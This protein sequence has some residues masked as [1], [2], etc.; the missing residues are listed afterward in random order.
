MFIVCGPSVGSAEKVLFEDKGGEGYIAPGLEAGQGIAAPLTHGS[1]IT[2]NAPGR[3]REDDINLVASAISASAGHHGHSSPRGDGSDNL[4]P[5]PYWDGGEISDTLDSS[6]LAKQQAMPEKRRF[7]AV[8]TAASLIG[9]GQYAEGVGPLRETGGDCGGG[10]ET[11]ISVNPEVCNALGTFSGGPDDNDA[12]GAHIVIQDVRGGTRD[13][14]DSGQGIGISAENAPCYTLDGTSQHAVA[15]D[16]TQI[17]SPGNYSNP[18]E[19]DP[20]HPLAAGAHPPAIAFGWNKSANQTMR[21]DE[22][23]TDPL[24]GC[25]ESNPAICFES[26]FARNGRGAPSEIVPPLKAESGQTGKGDSAPLV[27]QPRYYANRPKMGGAPSEE[28]TTALSSQHK[29]GDCLPRVLAPTL[30][31]NQRNNSNPATEAEMHI[32]SGMTV[33]RLTPVE[34]EKLQAFP[35]GWTIPA[36]EHWKYADDPDWPLLPKGLDSA[37]YRALGNAVTV[38]AVRWIAERIRSHA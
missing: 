30:R 23:V 22:N 11:L 35:D 38:N 36:H 16:T 18:Q 29:S 27:F 7:A 24:M 32:Q 20:C 37:R 3:R 21:V 14:V 5:G 17:T 10:S 4:I 13:R 25:P 34:C 1:G 2:G 6:M 9:H 12:Q 31:T 33:R 26:R 8:V 15:F 19:G 28:S